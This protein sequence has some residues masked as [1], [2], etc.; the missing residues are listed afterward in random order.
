MYV[1]HEVE[2]F[3][4]MKVENPIKKRKNSINAS[5][6]T[7]RSQSISEVRLMCCPIAAPGNDLG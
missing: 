7:K 6:S 4:L 2:S 1:I 3:L 5:K